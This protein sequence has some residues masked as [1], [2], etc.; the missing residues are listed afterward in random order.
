MRPSD[1]GEGEEYAEEM[2][3][4][5]IEEKKILHKRKRR[6]PKIEEVSF[7]LEMFFK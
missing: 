1:G 7:D 2:K 4:M 6:N 5:D 3:H